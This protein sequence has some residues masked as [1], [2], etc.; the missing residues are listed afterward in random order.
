M[1]FTALLNSENIKTKAAVVA[2]QNQNHTYFQLYVLFLN[3]FLGFLYVV[4]IWCRPDP[5]NQ[6]GN[7]TKS[8]Y[9]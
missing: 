9:Y 7:K 1:H 5:L 2:T 6:L 4:S 3:I 8:S